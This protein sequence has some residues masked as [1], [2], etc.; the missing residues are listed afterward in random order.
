MSDD[1]WKNDLRHRLEQGLAACQ[2]EHEAWSAHHGLSETRFG[3][4]C[5]EK[6]VFEV[7]LPG[8]EDPAPYYERWGRQHEIDVLRGFL[9]R[10]LGEEVAD[11][12]AEVFRRLTAVEERVGSLDNRLKATDEMIRNLPIGGGWD[13]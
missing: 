12:Q 7:V 13:R 8:G 10:L 5:G 9:T 3:L 1:N 11:W 2:N 4:D 6:T